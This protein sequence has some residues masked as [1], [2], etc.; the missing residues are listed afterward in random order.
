MVQGGATGALIIEGIEIIRPIVAGLPEQLLI[1]RDYEVNQTNPPTSPPPPS[2]ELSVNYIPVPYPSYPTAKLLVKPEE[3]QFWRILN[4]ASDTVLSLSFLYDNIPQ[5]V[6]IISLDGIP[7]SNPPNDNVLEQTNMVLSP[8]SRVEF[9]V[10]TPALT[11]ITAQLIT[12]SV[13]TG[14]IGDYDPSRPLI[15]IIPDNNAPPPDYII[16]FPQFPSVASLSSS[17]SREGK[18]S[19]SSMTHSTQDEIK[20]TLAKTP[21]KIRKMFFSEEPLDPD[22][23]TGA[24]EFFITLSDD[25]PETFTDSMKPTIIVYQNMTEDWI[26]QNRAKEIH[27]FHIHQGNYLLLEKN[28]Q[29]VSMEDMQFMDTVILPYWEGPSSPHE[30]EMKQ[31]MKGTDRTDTEER[32]N[33]KYPSI[34]IRLDFSRF[35][36]GT[37]V[38]HCHILEHEDAGMMRIIQVLPSSDTSSDSSKTTTTT[39]A[40]TNGDTDLATGGIFMIVTVVLIV[41]LVLETLGILFYCFYQKK[42]GFLFSRGMKRS[43]QNGGFITLSEF[44]G[45]Y[46]VINPQFSTMNEGGHLPSYG[47]A[48]TGGVGAAGVVADNNN[49]QSVHV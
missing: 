18:D 16:P 25:I 12:N 34:K 48:G 14:P 27:V 47:G 4:A 49:R 2:F 42:G 43:P 39:T 29:V 33:S 28:D 36:I 1:F 8:G 15:T 37:F 10:T 9:I 20:A 21:N 6:L 44:G 38:F 19:P 11:V 32:G 5:N 23:P 17:E 45:K 40:K 24:A 22:N 26:I 31:G 13:D 35:G 7:I 3:K 30:M 41:I 46:T